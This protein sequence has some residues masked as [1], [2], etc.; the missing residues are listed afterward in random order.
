MR[1]TVGMR[2]PTTQITLGSQTA[3]ENPAYLYYAKAINDAQ[4]AFVVAV[5]DRNTGNIDT[6][7]KNLDTAPQLDAK[8]DELRQR[9]KAL[10]LRAK[11]EPAPS[12][13]AEKSTATTLTQDFVAWRSEYNQWLKTAAKNYNGLDKIETK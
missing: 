11:E 7:V 8:A 4:E 2:S 10:L 9:L 6:A 5:Q 1:A 13:R 3:P 12:P